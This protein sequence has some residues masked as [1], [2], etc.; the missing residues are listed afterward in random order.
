MSYNVSANPKHCKV[1]LLGTSA[2]VCI[3]LA[4]PVMADD[5]VITSS[6]GT[7]NG[8]IGDTA[9]DGSDTVSLGVA[10]ETASNNGNGIKTNN[11]VGVDDGNTITVSGSIK[12][13]GEKARGIYNVGNTNTTTVSGSITTG[14][15]TA[16]GIRNLGDTNSTDVSGRLIT[17]GK[18]GY[19]L[20]NKGDKNIVYLSGVIS[21]EG[22]QAHGIWNVGDRNKTTFSGSISTKGV[23]S[24]GVSNT[25][26]SNEVNASGAIVTEGFTGYGLVN[27]GDRNKTTFS[28]TIETK[29]GTAYGFWNIGHTSLTTLSG[30]IVTKGAFSYGVYN[31]GNSNTTDVSGSITTEGDDAHGIGSTGNENTITVS[32]D[33]TTKGVGA[34]GIIVA[35]NENAMTLSG[36]IATEGNFSIGINNLGNSNTTDVSGSIAMTG[37]DIGGIQNQGNTNTTTVSG[38]VSVA[39][40]DAYGI[41]NNGNNNAVTI[42]GTVKATGT[43][44]NALENISGA[45]NSFTLDEGATII[46]KITAFFP[47]TNNQLTFNLGQDVSYAYS[48]GGNGVGIGAGEWT[49]SDQDGRTPVVTADGTNCAYMAGSIEVCNLV[50]AVGSGNAIYHNELTYDTNSSMIDSLEPHESN[51]WVNMYGGSSEQDYK[52]ETSGTGISIGTPFAL[53]STYYMD[54]A[55]NT[56]NTNLDIGK[57]KHHQITAK[58]YNVGLILRDLVPAADWSVEAFG[59][60][61]RNS[62]DGKRK[63]MNNDTAIGSE[64]VTASYSGTEVLVG[65]DAQYR[66]SMDRNLTFTG[67]VNANLSNEKLKAYS[68]SKYFAWDARTLMQTTGGISAGLEHKSGAMTTFASLGVER[69]SLQKGKT[70]S[71]T[72]NGTAGSYTDPSTGDTYRKVSVGFD[73][74]GSNNMHFTAAV[75]G[76]SSTGGISGNS[77]KLGFNWRF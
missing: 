37:N 30:S 11:V 21:T 44:T 77:A 67:G 55:F 48:V 16:H 24:A 53:K 42:S 14:G 28:G 66:K 20:S 26:D 36:T 15:K 72:N 10:L 8:N 4:A 52:Y 34:D 22:D 33:I 9:I 54:L 51:T 27:Q 73:Y 39:G 65:L 1:F 47:A 60:V 68:E 59:F 43:N 19:A 7:T 5:F 75:E 2:L 3:A 12:T 69:N 41:S 70:A 29:G 23:L 35:N 25:G 57:S 56:S 50:T 17:S 46:G 76:F 62:Y 58:S 49:F 64:T 63:V 32:G 31:T 6:D 40:T 71:Y 61:G 13:A 18:K 38:S 45:G 74:A